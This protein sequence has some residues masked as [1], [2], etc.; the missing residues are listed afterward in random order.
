MFFVSR[1]VDFINLMLLF[2]LCNLSLSHFLSLTLHVCMLV[3]KCI[4]TTCAALEEAIMAAPEMG[5]QTGVDLPVQH[6][7]VCLIPGVA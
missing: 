3:C 1:G 5:V 7:G 2:C 4:L 6:Y